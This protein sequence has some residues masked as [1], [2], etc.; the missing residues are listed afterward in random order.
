MFLTRGHAV[1]FQVSDDTLV[2]I[3]T[4]ILDWHLTAKGFPTAVKGVLPQIIS[5]TLQVYAQ[6][7]ATLN[8][9]T[10]LL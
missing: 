8:H 10:R 3:F 1:C 5:S 9:L 7:R 4:S 2:Q 6:V